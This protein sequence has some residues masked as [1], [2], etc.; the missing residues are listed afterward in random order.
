M[1]FGVVAATSPSR[2]DVMASPVDSSGHVVLFDGV[3]NLCNGWV[4]FV[5]RRDR[6]RRFCFASLQ[7]TFGAEVLRRHGLP[8]DYLGS[9]LFLE[10]GVLFAKSDAVLRIARGLRWPWPLLSIFLVVPRSVRDVV[11]DWVARNRYRWFG[12][13]ETC[14]LPSTEDA[15]RFLT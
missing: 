11:Y 4:R 6:R 8:N 14:M 10:N 1:R 5:V 12:K 9:I 15:G 13:R 2:F 7:S 3:C